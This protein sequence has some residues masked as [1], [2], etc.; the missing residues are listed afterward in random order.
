M[1]AEDILQRNPR[2]LTRAKSF[3]TF[4]SFGP[5]LVTLDEVGD[6][7]RAAGAHDASTARSTARTSSRT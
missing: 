1:T 6:L 3:E 7:A 4:F 5:E 2:F